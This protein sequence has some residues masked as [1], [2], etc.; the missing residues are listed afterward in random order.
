MQSLL[1]VLPKHD[2]DPCGLLVGIRGADA[3]PPY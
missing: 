2:P 3:A 1:S